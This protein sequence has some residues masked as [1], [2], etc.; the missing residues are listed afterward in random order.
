V[1]SSGAVPVDWGLT[2]PITEVE[3]D[4]ALVTALA[5]ARPAPSHAAA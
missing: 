5:C 3:A 2:C 4:G 1:V